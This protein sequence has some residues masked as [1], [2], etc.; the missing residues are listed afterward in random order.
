MAKIITVDQA[1]DMIKDGD[2]LCIGGFLGVG[3]PEPIIDALVKSG[4]KDFTLI[5]ND[6]G[7]VDK[8]NG[9]MVVNKQFKKIIATHIGTNKETGRQMTEG[10]TEV[11]LIP[12][13]TLAEMLRAK[14]YGLGGILT[15]TG[16]GTEV[17]KGRQVLTLSGKDYILEEAIGGDVSLLQAAVVDKAGNMYFHGSTQN[18]NVPMAGASKINIVYAEKVVEIGE[19]DPDMVKVPGVFIDY[20]VDGGNL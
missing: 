1:V 11:V 17:Q 4:K 15:P 6:T 14:A 10:E 7:F 18:F 3:S 5:S 19:L 9:K 13:G 8:G 12:Q 16:L 20:I 2:T